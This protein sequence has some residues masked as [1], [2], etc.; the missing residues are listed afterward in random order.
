V[1]QDQ[2]VEEEQETYPDHRKRSADG[3]ESGQLAGVVLEFLSAKSK[4]SMAA[5]NAETARR[6]PAPWV[7]GTRLSWSWLRKNYG[8]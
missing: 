2:V 5:F 7:A 4:D 6:P 1:N 8:L 3:A